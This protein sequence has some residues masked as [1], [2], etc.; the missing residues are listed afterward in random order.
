MRSRRNGVGPPPHD[1]SGTSRPT[2]SGATPRPS[3]LR[4]R[5]VTP[6]ALEGGI[7]E[8]LSFAD[9]LHAPRAGF[10]RAKSLAFVCHSLRS[11][12]G[13]EGLS[14]A[15]RCSGFHASPAGK[16]RRDHSRRSER[17]CGG[18]STALR[19]ANCGPPPQEVI[20]DPVESCSDHPGAVCLHKAPGETSLPHSWLADGP[21]R[22]RAHQAGENRG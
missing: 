6:L 2:R 11:E 13:C 5:A 19:A 16:R 1:C 3:Q 8:W 10:A 9:P 17:G 21:P 14:T 7:P 4:F 20:V 22:L 18:L 12:R 15:L